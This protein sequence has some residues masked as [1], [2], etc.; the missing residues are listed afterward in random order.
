[1]RSAHTAESIHPF[2]QRTPDNKRPLNPQQLIAP[3]FEPIAGAIA[4]M[5]ALVDRCTVNDEQ[6]VPQPGGFYGGW[7]TSWIVGPF[8][9]IPG[10][11]TGSEL[12]AT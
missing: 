8:K 11:R 10:S 2:L 9:G 7:V 1:L 6:V 5:A 4:V 12:P 3:G